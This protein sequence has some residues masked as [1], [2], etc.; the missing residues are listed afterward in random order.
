MSACPLVWMDGCPPAC[1]PGM[2]ELV[3]TAWRFV[4][5]VWLLLL[6]A[7]AHGAGGINF[8]YGDQNTHLPLQPGEEGEREEAGGNGAARRNAETRGIRGKREPN[9]ISTSVCLNVSFPFLTYC[10]NNSPGSR[11]APDRQTETEPGAGIQGTG[12]RR[13]RRRQYENNSCSVSLPPHNKLIFHPNASSEPFTK[14]H[15][16]P[17]RCQHRPQ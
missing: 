5:A 7:G 15:G 12:R 1:L 6:L 4:F 10:G 9:G 16:K 3:E 2:V 11:E 8:S 17:S 13:K 14:K